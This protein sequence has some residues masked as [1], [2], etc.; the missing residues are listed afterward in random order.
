MKPMQ[1]T[2]IGGGMIVHD[3]LLPSLY[4][5][6]RI[7]AVG[8]IAVVEASAARLQHLVNDRYAAAFPGQSFTAHPALDSDPKQEDF[9]RYRSVIS[10]MPP[11]NLAIVAT[12]DH[13]HFDVIRFCLEHDQHVMS[14]KPL[15]HRHEEA[16]TIEKLARQRGLFVG[17]EYHKRFDRR[18]LEAR[19]LYK[20]GRFGQFRLGYACLVEPYRYRYS[21]FQN[22]FT[23]ENADPFT[24]IGCHYVDQVYFITGLRPTS[25]VM[26]GVEGTFPNGNV[27]WMWANGTVTFENG[28]VLSI[29]AGLGYPE[30]GAGSNDQGITLYC[31][32]PDGKDSPQEGGCIIVHNDQ[33]RGVSHG[34]I[35]DTAAGAH[36]RFVNPDYMRLVPWTGPGLKPVGYGYDS[37]EAIVQSAI[38]VA[39]AGDLT[40]RQAV[41]AEID[42]AGLIATP[43]NSSIN[44][45]VSEAARLSL[46]EAGRRIAIHY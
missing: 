17:I 35:D 46:A 38:R 28:A 21:N 37:V 3:Q 8:D 43:G 36:F 15:V 34:Y 1:T 41:L 7:G 5:L 23:K 20:A 33:F 14:T 18:A 16:V 4:H 29:N 30:R 11:G 42:Q 24:Y 32:G 40:S 6:Q 25:V 9:Q 10:K 27:A 44:E 2:F 19:A 39:S 13:L 22:W 26:T 45:K 31:E 12:P